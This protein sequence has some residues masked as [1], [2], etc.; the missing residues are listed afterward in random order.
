[1]KA[2]KKWLKN[3]KYWGKIENLNLLMFVSLII[4]PRWKFGYVDWMVKKAYGQ[5]K[6]KLLSLN[7]SYFFESLFDNYAATTAAKEASCSSSTTSK[8]VNSKECESNNDNKKRY[9]KLSLM[10]RDVL[11]IPVST[12]ASESAFSTGGRILDSFRTSLAPS[13]VEALICA[14]D[15]LRTT[16]SPLVI[17]DAL[18]EMERLQEDMKDLILQHAVIMIDEETES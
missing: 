17:E 12:V 13:T 2:L 15:W 3:D 8:G 10:A 11:V 16:Y 18:N 1:M 6:G 9:P 14:R 5:D 7:I 4:D